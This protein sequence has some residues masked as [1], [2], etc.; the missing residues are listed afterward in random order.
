[1]HKTGTTSLQRF[2]RKNFKNLLDSGFEYPLLQLNLSGEVDSAPE[3]HSKL[4]SIIFLDKPIYNG[5]KITKEQQQQV[6]DY[7]TQ[8]LANSNHDTIIIA[9]N[10]SR[11]PEMSL[12]R[13][14]CY[15][16]RLGY[17]ILPFC[18]VRRPSDWINSMIAQ[19][20]GG[21]RSKMVTITSAVHWFEQ[22]GSIIRD[23]FETINQ[24]FPDTKSFDFDVLLAEFGGSVNWFIDVLKIK[25]YVDWPRS[26]ERLSAHTVRFASMVNGVGLE[27]NI[28]RLFSECI[29]INPNVLNIPGLGFCSTEEEIAPIKKL[30]EEEDDWFYEN[31]RNGAIQGQIKYSERPDQLTEGQL[32]WIQENLND[33]THPF[34]KILCRYINRR[35][36]SHS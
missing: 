36:S 2:C 4:C 21:P 28:S 5:V 33:L 17:N 15:F 32:L 10:I 6:S 30:I 31:F 12:V 25:D 11:F 20:V 27:N 14:K 22:K 13:L 9:E 24:V 23:R 18:V 19:W 29:R 26:N 3:N 8:K 1:M 7:F 34:D 35:Y 16:E